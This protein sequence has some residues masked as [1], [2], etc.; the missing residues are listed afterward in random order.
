MVKIIPID[1][2]IFQRGRAQPPTSDVLE[3]GMG[4]SLRLRRLRVQDQKAVHL[5]ARSADLELAS[6]SAELFALRAA[7]L[8]A[9]H[10]RLKVRYTFVPEKVPRQTHGKTQDAPCMVDLLSFTPYL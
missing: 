1:F 6:P 3:I 7:E 10:A 5:C 2:H 4:D 9:G 8:F